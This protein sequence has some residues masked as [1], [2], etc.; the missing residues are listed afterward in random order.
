[1]TWTSPAATWSRA[2][3]SATTP[4]K[5]LRMSS[6][7]SKDSRRAGGSVTSGP[8]NRIGRVMPEGGGQ[9]GRPLRLEERARYSQ[10]LE[11]LALELRGVVD[12]EETV[13]HDDP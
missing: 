4:G 3:S 7:S 8:S 11:L 6:I 5:T 12:V 10:G 1:M 2:P 13:G 9:I